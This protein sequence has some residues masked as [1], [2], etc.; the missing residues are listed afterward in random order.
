VSPDHP[1]ECT[2]RIAFRDE[3][4]ILCGLPFENIDKF[5]F[6]VGAECMTNAVDRI[7]PFLMYLFYTDQKMIETIADLE[8]SSAEAFFSWL[9]EMDYSITHAMELIYA[10]IKEK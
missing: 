2:Y 1:D 9:F 7:I 4:H 8:F 5:I 10:I 3:S 6:H